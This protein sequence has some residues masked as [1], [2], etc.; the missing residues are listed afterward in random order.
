M[1]SRKKC[2]GKTKK[3][4]ACRAFSVKGSKYCQ[5]HDPALAAARAA[6]RKAG[7]ESRATPEGDPVELMGPEDVRTGLAAVIGSTW[8]LANTGERSRALISGYLAALRTFEVGEL[9]ERVAALEEIL[10]ESRS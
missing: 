4:K 6:W 7:G 1:A 10:Q 2:A 3:G 5:A 8:K 9:E